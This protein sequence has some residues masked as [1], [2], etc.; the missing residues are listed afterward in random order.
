MEL[1]AVTAVCQEYEAKDEIV[2]HEER[3]CGYD[4]YCTN[5]REIHAVPKIET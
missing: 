4:L 1:A 2:S 5:G 3:R